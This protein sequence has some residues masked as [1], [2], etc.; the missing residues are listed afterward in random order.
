MYF[1]INRL[2]E[3]RLAKLDFMVNFGITM[4]E[5]RQM[6]DAME[7]GGTYEQVKAATFKLIPFIQILKIYKYFSWA[8][9]K[10]HS[11]F[12]IENKDD[13]SEDLLSDFK[14]DQK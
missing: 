2:D 4:Q 3:S 1:I 8:D 10:L 9:K 6:H 11:V 5:I 7:H 13:I 12:F 14:E